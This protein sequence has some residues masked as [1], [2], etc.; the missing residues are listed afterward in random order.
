[1]ILLPLVRIEAIADAIAFFLIALLVMALF[2][3][4]GTILGRTFEWLGLGC[5]DTLGGGVLGFMQGV[6][7]V[8]LG[9]LVA[10]AFFPEA[11]WLAQSRLPRQFFGALI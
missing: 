2:N 3:L 6:V 7:L 9:V 10:V 4:L 1:M 5:L 8:M 11:E